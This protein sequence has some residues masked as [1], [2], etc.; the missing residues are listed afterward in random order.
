MPKV[1]L[2]VLYLLGV[3]AGASV[4]LFTGMLLFLMLTEFS[5]IKNFAPEVKGKGTELDPSRREFT[6][7]TWN[8]GY[9]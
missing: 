7:L 6:F 1:L 8:I 4:L 3:L 9:A 2:K 5:P